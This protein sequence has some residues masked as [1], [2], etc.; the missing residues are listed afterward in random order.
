MTTTHKAFENASQV[1]KF[2]TTLLDGYAA[3]YNSCLIELD[4]KSSIDHWMT[5]D[6]DCK[7]YKAPYEFYIAIRTNGVESSERNEHNM[8]RIEFFHDTCICN[9]CIHYLASIKK[10]IVDYT[11]AI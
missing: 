7:K 8:S 9:I 1:K 6:K 3:I 11:R 4:A 5:E 10:Y 2:I